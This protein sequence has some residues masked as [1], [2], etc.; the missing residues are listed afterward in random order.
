MPIDKVMSLLGMVSS[1]PPYVQID[2]TQ[3]ADQ[4]ELMIA[5]GIL[6][7]S[8]NL[9]ILSYWSAVEKNRPFSQTETASWVPAFTGR[10]THVRSL[11][12]GLF[13]HSNSTEVYN[14]GGSPST[15]PPI[16]TLDRDCLTL[17]GRAVGTVVWTGDLRLGDLCL[18]SG[19]TSQLRPVM[20]LDSEDRFA[21]QIPGSQSLMEACWRTLLVDQ[22]NTGK[23]LTREQVGNS[24]APPT[25]RQEAIDLMEQPGIRTRFQ[26]LDGRINFITSCGNLGLARETSKIGDIVVV[27]QGGPVPYIIRPHSTGQTC[28][29][30]QGEWLVCPLCPSRQ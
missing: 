15:R 30:F 10:P 25:L 12:P 13:E 7:E 18:P 24:H 28:Y 27:F 4:V 1:I 5:R 11:A 14:A 2:Y 9:D 17:R 8:G 22:W 21:I 16:F 19:V 29:T 3:S 20:D 6:Q 26:F 23:R